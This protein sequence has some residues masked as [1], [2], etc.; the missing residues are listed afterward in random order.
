MV[1]RL[2]AAKYWK[3]RWQPREKDGVYMLGAFMRLY[4]LRVATYSYLLRVQSKYTSTRIS[5]AYR[6]RRWAHVERCEA[7]IEHWSWIEK[8]VTGNQV[9]KN[10]TPAVAF[11]H[12]NV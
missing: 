3:A 9:S 10:K 6:P 8:M 7:S 5:Y 1:G 2:V 4:R 11:F 12:G